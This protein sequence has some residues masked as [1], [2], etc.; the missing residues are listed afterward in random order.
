MIKIYCPAED[1]K[2][3]AHL[4]IVDTTGAGDTYTAAF[5]VRLNELS[6]AKQLEA[7][8]DDSKSPT[9][10]EEELLECM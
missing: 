4:K 5:A 3:H 2:K 1:I 9:L 6:Q 7:V 8:A 10:S